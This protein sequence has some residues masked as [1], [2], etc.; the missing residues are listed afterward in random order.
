[1]VITPDGKALSSPTGAEIAAV[2]GLST[3]PAAEFYDLIVIGGGPAG[4]G[5]AVYGASEGLRT[6]LVER[7]A[8]GGQAGQSS[9][10][11]NYLGF[12]DGVSGSQLTDRAR[13]QA[14]KF[15]AEVLTAR[16]AVALEARGSARVITFSDG[17]E[18]AA[19]AVVL[20][21]GVS[22][23]ALEA[24]GC[25]TS[26]AAASTTARR[27][28]RRRRAPARTSTSSAAP[29]PP[30]RPRCSS[31]GTPVP[32]PSSYA[33]IAGAVDVALPDRA[34]PGDRERH[35]YAMGTTVV[36][37]HGDDHLEASRVCAGGTGKVETVPCG[38]LFVFIGA[39]PYTDWLGDA[40]V[41]DSHGFVRTGPDL[42][43]EGQ[44][45][46]GWTSRP[47]SVVPGVIGARRVRRGRR[48]F[49]VGQA[50]RLGG[51]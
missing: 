6:V 30:V 20:A 24:P 50:G 32:S 49:A 12:P 35:G 37:A 33:A 42:L 39:A 28:P 7:Q 15:G 47:R 18:I 13:R 31:P 4:L 43:A 1:M 19:H 29:T 51:R 45:P 11:E 9:R 38:H 41:R 44:R 16:D 46:A 36:E 14:R 40:I 17:S 22:Y 8:T 10:I 21:S 26:P 48:T 2:V 25:G 27:P 5:A 3:E 34:A 23:R